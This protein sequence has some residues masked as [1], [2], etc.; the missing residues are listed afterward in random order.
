MASSPSIWATGYCAERAIRAGLE[1]VTTARLVPVAP[2]GRLRVRVGI[3][4]GLVVVGDLVGAG[5]AHERGV[6]GETPNLAARLQTLAEP[7][8]VV[9]AAS[10]H[11]LTGEIFE[12]EE[13]GEVELKGFVTPVAAWRVRGEGAVESRFEALHSAAALAPRRTRGGD[14]AAAPALDTGEGG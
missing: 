2:G 3:A 1:I 11:K 4:T 13:L 14:S 6:V 12:Y 5:E 7:G 10:T 9:I 8:S